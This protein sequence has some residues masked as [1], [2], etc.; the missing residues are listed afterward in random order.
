MPIVVRVVERNEYD[1]WL[2]AKQSDAIKAME[3][4]GKEWTM[5]ELMV[6]GEASYLKNCA[7]CHQANGEGIPPAFPALKGSPMAIGDMQT[8]VA[9]VLD[10][11]AGTAM[12]AFGSQ[13]DAADIAAIVTYERNAWGNNMGDMIQPKEILAIQ[14]AQ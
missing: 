13:L 10:G 2:A 11:K 7:S 4:T 8:H 9:M 1:E 14:A 3:L 12:Q 5:D 6:R